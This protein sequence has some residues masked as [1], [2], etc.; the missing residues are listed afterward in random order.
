MLGHAWDGALRPFHYSFST[1]HAESQRP[2]KLMESLKWGILWLDNVFL[3]YIQC[4]LRK[5]I[6][7]KSVFK[8][9]AVPFEM[10]IHS[11][12]H[13]I[14]TGFLLHARHCFRSWRTKRKRFLISDNI[15]SSLTIIITA[16]HIEFLL[17]TKVF[18]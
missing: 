18:L 15:Y 12:I 9:N 5:L 7:P 11:F 2:S 17:Y 8:R 14:A 6:L 10:I 4:Y 13:Q 3:C 1:N 16:P